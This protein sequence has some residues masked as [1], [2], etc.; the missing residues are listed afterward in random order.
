VGLFDK[1]GGSTADNVVD[2]CENQLTLFALSFHEAVSIVTDTEAIM[3]ATGR[4]FVQSSLKGG[5]RTKWLGCIDNL[6]QLVTRK[7]FLYLPMSE[8]TL[9]ACP[10]L[11]NFC[12]SSWKASGG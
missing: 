12:N 9:K 2:Y 3:I 11:V 5:T 1:T 10:N 8:G 4:I 6:L 7:A